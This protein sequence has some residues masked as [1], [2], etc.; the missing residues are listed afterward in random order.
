MAA[1]NDLSVGDYVE[2]IS[3][4][5]E[6]PVG[7]RGTIK[8]FEGFKRCESD[9]PMH[10]YKWLARDL[11]QFKIVG[12]LQPETKQQQEFQMNDAIIKLFPKTADAVLVN[13]YFSSQ[14]S[15]PLAAILYAGKEKEVLAEAVRLEEKATAK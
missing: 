5:G 2:V 11:Y 9:V 8:I 10:N 15:Q 4:S 7:T 6:F 14:F 13:K 1:L 12:K 3:S